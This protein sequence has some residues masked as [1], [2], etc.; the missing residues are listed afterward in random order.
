MFAP[1]R[2]LPDG[3]IPILFSISVFQWLQRLSP[4]IAN[5]ALFIKTFVIFLPILSFSIEK[6]KLL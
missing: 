3:S 2:I 4:K 1:S 6:R 5:L